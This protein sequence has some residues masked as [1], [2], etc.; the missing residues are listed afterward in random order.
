MTTVTICDVKRHAYTLL[1]DAYLI[2]DINT[3]KYYISLGLTLDNIKY[4]DN[5]IFRTVC[6]HGYLEIA[7]LLVSMGLS[8]KDIKSRNN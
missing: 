8:L 6:E 3:V 7:K 5:I 2:N 1:R 4:D